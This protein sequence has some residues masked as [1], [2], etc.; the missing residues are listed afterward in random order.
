MTSASLVP[1][2]NNPD[3]EPTGGLSIGDTI[4]EY[5]KMSLPQIRAM[6][7]SSYSGLKAQLAQ[8]MSSHSD[9]TLSISQSMGLLDGW[10]LEQIRETI[11]TYLP[12]ACDVCI[13]RNGSSDVRTFRDFVATFPSEGIVNY[14]TLVD[15]R[16]WLEAHTDASV[17][18]YMVNFMIVLYKGHLYTTQ[19]FKGSL[20]FIPDQASI[21][22][23]VAEGEDSLLPFRRKN[24]QPSNHI[25]WFLA[26]PHLRGRFF[27]GWFE[28]A[29]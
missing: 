7:S 14:A 1:F 20:I 12:P 8:I 2:H 9:G 21:R 25:A 27:G 17:W 28:W 4:R 18:E 6:Q 23:R 29:N 13:L 24:Q 15:T 3:P 16:M 26:E 19:M 10:S 22:W 5:S 11:F